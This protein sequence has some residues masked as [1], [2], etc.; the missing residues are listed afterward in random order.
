MYRAVSI[1]QAED[2]N[3]EITF[4]QEFVEIIE[5]VRFANSHKLRYDSIE[6][7]LIAEE[8]DSAIFHIV[9]NDELKVFELKK[10]SEGKLVLTDRDFETV[11]ITIE[12][13][14]SVPDL[15]GSFGSLAY[16]VV[17]RES[18]S[19]VISESIK[20]QLDEEYQKKIRKKSIFS[21]L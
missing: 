20:Q 12:D 7:K 3:L 17:N 14:Y 6:R 2:F 10:A 4:S 19:V 16:G 9:T 18:K 1:W 13:F 15:S 21:S 11:D 8:R 5:A